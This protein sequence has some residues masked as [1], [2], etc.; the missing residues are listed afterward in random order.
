MTKDEL[1]EAVAGNC[2]SKKEASEAVNAMLDTITSALSKG[3]DV[4]LTG[5]GKFSVSKRAARM[6]V[7]PRTGE[8]LQIAATTV[9]KFKAGKALK[10]AVK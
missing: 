7:N 6:G 5:F 1:I 2:C 3:N 8:K 4:V 10:D 9:P